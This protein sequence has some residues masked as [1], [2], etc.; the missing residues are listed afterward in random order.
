MPPITYPKC[1]AL[2]AI[3][4]L[5]SPWLPPLV[6]HPLI[7]RIHVPRSF[8]HATATAVPGGA[9]CCAASGL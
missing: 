2:C 3:L 8:S 4:A 9:F 7:K 5:R 6:V 1:L